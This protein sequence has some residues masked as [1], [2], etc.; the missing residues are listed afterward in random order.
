M[1]FILT[2]TFGIFRWL[3][4]FHFLIQGPLTLLIYSHKILS[5]FLLFL[6]FFLCN[7]RFDM[8]E[9]FV[10]WRPSNL[11]ILNICTDKFCFPLLPVIL[12][13]HQ[14]RRPHILGTLLMKNQV[15][16]VQPGRRFSHHFRRTHILETGLMKIQV[17]V[18]PGR[19]VSHQLSLTLK[20]PS[21]MT[22]DSIRCCEWL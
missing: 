2:I 21:V 3:I 22:V 9:I 8:F 15:L 13:R 14:P 11:H 5:L 20:I 6:T 17:L 12:R 10:N 7:L 16:V 19:R 4:L 1:L 18:Q